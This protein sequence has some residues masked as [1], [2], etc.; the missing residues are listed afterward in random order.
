[1]FN[2][3]V[4]YASIKFLLII[5]FDACLKQSSFAKFPKRMCQH[6]YQDYV[7]MSI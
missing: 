3:F 4:A 1:M 6:M 5:C 7:F 2:L